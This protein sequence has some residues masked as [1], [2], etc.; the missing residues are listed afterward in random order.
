MA[1]AI[2]AHEFAE[3]TQNGEVLNLLDV[4]EVFEYLSFNIGGKNI[5]VARLQA[6]LIDLPYNKTDELIVVCTVG[7][8]SETACGILEEGGYKNVRNLAGGLVALQ[9]LKHKTD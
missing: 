9:K 8:R 2:K 5:P 3:R 4:R 7:K 1:A 6:S